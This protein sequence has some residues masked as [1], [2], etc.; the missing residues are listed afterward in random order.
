M[1]ETGE[2]K[3]GVRVWSGRKEGERGTREGDGVVM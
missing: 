1:R 3:S 2:G